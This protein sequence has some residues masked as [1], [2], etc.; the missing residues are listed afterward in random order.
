MALTTEALA[1]RL[2]TQMLEQ[3]TGAKEGPA[4]DAYCTALAAAVVDT[5]LEDAE[6][7]GGGLA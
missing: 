6:V 3:D 2:K 7:E 4:L 1:A 5:L